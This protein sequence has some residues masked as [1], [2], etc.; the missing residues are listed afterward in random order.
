MSNAPLTG[1]DLG[2]GWYT[3]LEN[4]NGV[5][6]LTV[7]NP[8]KGQRITLEHESVARLRAIFAKVG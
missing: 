4:E 1:K 3:T 6:T 7:R 2:Q 8:D 5:E